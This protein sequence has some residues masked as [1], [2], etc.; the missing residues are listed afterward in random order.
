MIQFLKYLFT[1]SI[2]LLSSCTQITRLELPVISITLS[3]KSI[4]IYPQSIKEL[5]AII[6]PAS[7]PQEII[8]KSDNTAIATVSE[9]GLVTGV[10]EGQTIIR[11]V[12]KYD[13][14][15]SAQCSVTV[16][17]TPDIKAIEWPP[18]TTLSKGETIWYSFQAETG[19]TYSIRWNDKS[20]NSNSVTNLTDIVVSAYKSDKI[21]PYFEDIDSAYIVPQTI[22]SSEDGLIYIKITGYRISDAGNF[23]LRF[24]CHD[25]Y[26]IETLSIIENNI[27][28]MEEFSIKLTISTTPIEAIQS[29]IWSSDNK[30]IATV[31]TTGLITAISAGS[32][33]IRA[34]STANSSKLAQCFITVLPINH[35]SNNEWH[36]NSIESDEV[37]WYSFEGKA[38]RTSSIYWNDDYEGD[39]TKTCSVRVSA[40]KSNK[41]D[42]YFTNENYGYRTPQKITP[43]V[44]EKIYL[45]VQGYGSNS[46]GTFA[47]KFL[48]QED[49]SITSLTIN[50]QKLTLIKASTHTLKPT[51]FP[52]EAI[53]NVSW[54]SSNTSVATVSD[55]GV[56]TGIANG[57]A[58]IKATST[59]DN[60]KS[61]ECIISVKSDFT[62][63]NTIWTANSLQ[64]DEV[65]W[66]SFE[67]IAGKTYSI[68]TNDNLQGDTTKT[69]NIEVSAYKSDKINSYFN[70]KAYG[71]SSPE[72]IIASENGKIFLKIDGYWSHSSGTFAIK[73]LC[74]NEIPIESVNITKIPSTTFESTTYQLQ[75]SITPLLAV[76]IVTWSS[77]NE[78]IATVSDNGLVTALTPGTAVIRATST[79]DPL[80]YADCSTTITPPISLTSNEWT[81]GTFITGEVSWY[82]FDGISGKTYSIYWN[83]DN[84]GDNKKTADIYV[85][86]YKSDKIDSYF[87]KKA[88]GYKS[89]RTITPSENGK[90]YLKVEGYWSDSSGTFAIKYLCNNDIPIESIDI[91]TNS[92]IIREC[93]TSQLEYSI[94]PLI[95]IQTVNWSSLNESI[96]TV[97]DIGLVTAQYPGTTV[98]RATSTNDPLKYSDCSITVTPSTSLTTNVWFDDTLISGKIQWYSFDAIAGKTY[99][100]YLNDKNQGDNSKTATIY[101]SAFKSDK[102]D[103]YFTN[104]YYAYNYPE[105]ITPSENG[106]IYLQVKGY[107]SNSSGTFA[108]KY[109]CNS[110]IP[111]ESIQIKNN[112]STIPES[113]KHLFEYTITPEN[114]IQTVIWSSLDESIAI[115]SNDGVVTALSPGTTMIRATSTNEPLN[116]VEHSITITPSIALTVN[117]WTDDTLINRENKSYSFDVVAGKTYSIYWND[118]Y[119]TKTAHLYVSAYKSNKID[120]YFDRQSYGYTSPRK[121]TPSENG[122]IFLEV[123]ESWANYEVTFAIK[124]TEN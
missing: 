28:L 93:I 1:I 34:I 30:S 49:L 6:S 36:D 52:S 29:C 17:K 67:G 94:T 113:I 77:L 106:K 43:P 88:Y 20:G 64:N 76:Q 90:I 119:N 21:T 31:S 53:Q 59:Q 9:K 80:Q 92:L 14:S 62:L 73:Y 40:Y 118:W 41:I 99:S 110:D 10:S 25:D 102:I 68:Y 58:I 65:Q 12:F 50:D 100:I 123:Q 24:I 105:K 114:A 7:E 75:C 115:V 120:S 38:G 107:Y 104:Q 87:Y 82:S 3:S 32:T 85:S 54:T 79:N 111:I 19:K 117:E 15:K 60:T 71:Y 39:N 78:S 116:Y 4:E 51:I 13:E 83:D 103:S 16:A 63:E 44:N 84:D 96:A 69:A 98:I 11:A 109:L 35:L 47:I 5:T 81:D 22:I 95:A 27:T 55:A 18:E 124:Y 74:N 45:K 97:S 48:C 72:R 57:T 86:A 46:I 108:I 66:Y 2:I 89:P 61:A 8:W 33:I 91:V 56:V 23:S 121:I 26:P 101:V 122:K 112:K 70:N 42:T 37:Q